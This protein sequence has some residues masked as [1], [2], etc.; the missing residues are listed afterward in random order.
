MTSFDVTHRVLAL[1]AQ[2]PTTGHYAIS[3]A[4]ETIKMVIEPKGASRVFAAFGYY[5][6]YPISGFTADVIAV[7]DE[8]K[9]AWNNY[10]EIEDLKPFSVGNQFD[11]YECSLVKQQFHVD[12]PAYG[13]GAT[14][15]DPRKNIRL[16]LDTYLPAESLL[17]NDGIAAAHYVT[18]WSPVP[19]PVFK[20]LA[21]TE[22]NMDLVYA[23]G[24]GPSEPQWG[25]DKCVHSYNEKVLVTISTIDKTGISGENLWW[26]GERALRHICETYPIGSVRNIETINPKP[27][28]LGSEMLYSGE[29]V[30][31]YT[32]GKT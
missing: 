1:G 14:V 24:R 3:F 11:H 15:D 30:L 28:E 6:H 29:C 23:I 2:D 19:Y 7:G 32:R 20:V 12:M 18:C 4:D 22:K 21:S 26:Q 10:Y 9:D 27:I 17:E 5:A 25:A 13:T 16:L 31:D 8:I